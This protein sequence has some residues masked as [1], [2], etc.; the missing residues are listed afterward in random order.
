MNVSTLVFDSVDSTNTV[1]AEHARQ[2][3]AEGLCVVANQQTAGR[4]RYG[5]TWIS[6]PGAGLCFSIVLRPRIDPQHIT[7]I[8]LMAGVAVHDCLAE[9]GVSADIKWV[10]DLLVRGR[11]ISGILAETVETKIGQAIILGIGVNLTNDN[12]SDELAD[13]ATS[14]EAETG[15][16][17]SQQEIAERLVSF[18]S[19]FYEMLSAD[20][21]IEQTLDH[22]RQRS[23][24]HKGKTVRVSAQNETFEGETDG[25]EP[26]GALRVLLADGS[27]RIIGSADVTLLRPGD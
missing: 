1:A 8:T 9:F 12:F 19:Y 20:G 11:K 22:W 17:V 25:I 6:T 23:S 4:G 13:T 21:G 14:I 26:T 15:R 5:R 3:A 7:L 24:Y 10:N 16:T 2:G 27:V 18:L